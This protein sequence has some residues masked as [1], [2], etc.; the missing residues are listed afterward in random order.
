MKGNYLISKPLWSQPWEFAEF[1]SIEYN[2]WLNL[3][4][5]ETL[6]F[7]CVLMLRSNKQSK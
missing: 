1:R 5:N 6:R 7:N 2:K 4:N 3:Y